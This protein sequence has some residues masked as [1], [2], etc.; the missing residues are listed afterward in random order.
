MSDD[1]DD[2]DSLMG[3]FLD[4][5][6]L[7]ASDEEEPEEEEAEGDEEEDD[8]CSSR[9]SSRGSG[10]GSPTLA[11]PSPALLACEHSFPVVS[12]FERVRLLGV[13]AQQLAQLAPSQ[14]R[15]SGETDP[16]RIAQQEF[17]QGAVPLTV[18]RQHLGGVEVWPARGLLRTREQLEAAFDV[19]LAAATDAMQTD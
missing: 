11:Q 18:H 13:R 16:L 17:D 3:E 12:K 9:P 19:T 4:A 7:D 8:C 1:E 6:S 10:A 5:A 14:I 15:T 2:A